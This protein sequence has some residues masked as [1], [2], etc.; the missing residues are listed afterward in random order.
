MWG[1]PGD[2]TSPR[3][4]LRTQN[5]PC[6][7]K[8]EDLES[9]DRVEAALDGGK[10]F[11]IKCRLRSSKQI[12]TRRN[13]SFHFNMLSFHPHLLTWSVCFCMLR[14]QKL[15]PE[16][17]REENHSNSALKGAHFI[18]NLAYV[19]FHFTQRLGRDSLSNEKK[20]EKSKK[21]IGIDFYAL[22]KLFL[23]FSWWI[24]FNCNS[25][26]PVSE[27]YP[28]TTRIFWSL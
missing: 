4:S 21:F 2:E 22:V 15:S 28:P 12:Q 9:P 17:K 14:V 19:A 8:A 18:S 20:G 5:R 1:L 7:N 25:F 26:F 10:Y 11:S 13:A 3:C 16:I 24:S 27:I 23:P 6:C